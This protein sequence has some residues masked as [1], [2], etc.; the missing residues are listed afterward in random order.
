MGAGTNFPIVQY[1][2]GT[3]VIM[4]ACPRQLYFLKAI[5]NSF[6]DSTGLKV[7]FAK[8][9]MV[10]INVSEGRLDILANTFQCQKGS[11]PFTYLGLPQGTTKPRVIDYLSLV[12]KFERRMV[13]CS[14]FLT[15]AG[16]LTLVNSGQYPLATLSCAHSKSLVQL[17]S[18]WISIEKTASGGVHTL[19]QRNHLWQLG[20]WSASRKNKEV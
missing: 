8:S 2:D 20:R 13:A 12:R 6:V 7:N 18:K 9:F 19:T 15:Q 1:A 11:L 10:P 3:L 14:M 5:L 17:S 4:E 16:R